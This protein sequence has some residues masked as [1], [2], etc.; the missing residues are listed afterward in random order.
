MG[1]PNEYLI[2]T[3]SDV[4]E[5]GGGDDLVI[6]DHAVHRVALDAD[7]AAELA[8]FTDSNASGWWQDLRDLERLMVDLGHVV[9]EAHDWVLDRLM[10][11]AIPPGAPIATQLIDPQ[12]HQF[13]I[14]NDMVAGGDGDDWLVGDDAA[15][16]AA[17]LT[18]DGFSGLVRGLLGI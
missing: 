12:L 13:S 14:G 2:S 10:S 18:D 7:F 8:R 17:P 4:L 6:G 3:G 16:V 5:A 1:R 15:L 11:D 9:F